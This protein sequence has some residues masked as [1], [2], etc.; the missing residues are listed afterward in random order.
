MAT[1]DEEPLSEFI[2]RLKLTLPYREKAEDAAAYERNKEAI[3]RT[4]NMLTRYAQAANR[5]TDALLF[6]EV[7]PNQF[8][9]FKQ[10]YK[11]TVT[12]YKRIT[13]SVLRDDFVL[14]ADYPTPYVG[15]GRFHGP[16]SYSLRIPISH[17]SKEHV[18]E[19]VKWLAQSEYPPRWTNT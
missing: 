12:V 8:R 19:W 5:L 2:D 13:L 16:G 6:W 9:L 7:D 4:F 3:E 18:S 17:V 1:N 11:H 14:R 15:K 10:Q